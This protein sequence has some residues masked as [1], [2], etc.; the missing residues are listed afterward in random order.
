MIIC[1]KE[2]GPLGGIKIFESWIIGISLEEEIWDEVGFRTRI[3][4]LD[5]PEQPVLGMVTSRWLHTMALR[6]SVHSCGGK[7]V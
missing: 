7:E 2:S 3:N 5:A 1:V 6:K 4:T